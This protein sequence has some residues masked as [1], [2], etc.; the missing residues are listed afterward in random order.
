MNVSADSLTTGRM[1]PSRTNSPPVE[2]THSDNKQTNKQTDRHN[3]DFTPENSKHQIHQFFE[4][5]C[6]CH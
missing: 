6:F 5:F 2:L 1:S 3:N 4:I